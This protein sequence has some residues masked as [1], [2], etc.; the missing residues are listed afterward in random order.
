MI[1]HIPK[2]LTVFAKVFLH[3]ATCV[4]RGAEAGAGVYNGATATVAGAGG[5]AGAKRTESS[6]NVPAGTQFSKPSRQTKVSRLR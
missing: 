2:T 6:D 1:P 3:G 5:G 4:A